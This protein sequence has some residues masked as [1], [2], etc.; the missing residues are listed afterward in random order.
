MNVSYFGGKR[1]NISCILIILLILTFISGCIGSPGEI[2]FIPIPFISV[3]NVNSTVNSN[4][5][6]SAN[7]S[8]D[9]DGE[10]I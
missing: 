1:K 2:N 4:I 9:I 5:T 7:E 8:Y 3:S 10:I 6:F